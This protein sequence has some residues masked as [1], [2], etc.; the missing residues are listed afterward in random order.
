MSEV[1]NEEL[2]SSFEYVM[3][4]YQD[5]MG[6]FAEDV[7]LHLKNQYIR[8]VGQDPDE[9]DGE[10]ILAAVASFTSIGRIIDAV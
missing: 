1:D 2:V 5:Q 7:C 9:D 6:P 8:L 4:Y 10:S 3:G